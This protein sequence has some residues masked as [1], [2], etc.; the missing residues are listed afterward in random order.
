MPEKL[1]GRPDAG[2][3]RRSG[4]RP[5]YLPAGLRWQMAVTRAQGG[6]QASDAGLA[7]PGDHHLVHGLASR[8]GGRGAARPLVAPLRATPA[9]PEACMVLPVPAD[10]AGAFPRRR[11]VKSFTTR[12]RRRRR[13]GRTPIPK[14]I[15]KIVY[16]SRRGRGRE[17]LAE[18]TPGLRLSGGQVAWVIDLVARHSLAPLADSESQIP[19]GL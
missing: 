2:R 8:Y 14:Q 4:T 15:H 18:S 16:G 1:A 5:S 13:P 6:Q 7:E 11:L 12:K 9:T 17:W 3:R 10:P 19:A